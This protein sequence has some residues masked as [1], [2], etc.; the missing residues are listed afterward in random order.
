ML[1]HKGPLGLRNTGLREKNPLDKSKKL[2][3][4][5]IRYLFT[6]DEYLNFAATNNVCLTDRFQLFIEWIG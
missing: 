3:Y 6:I 5:L 4:Y 1:P 2:D